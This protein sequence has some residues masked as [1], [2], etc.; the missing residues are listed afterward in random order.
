MPLKFLAGLRAN[1]GHALGEDPGGGGRQIQ[2]DYLAWRKFAKV[3][4]AVSGKHIHAPRA[5][6][7]SEFH[8][9]RMIAHHK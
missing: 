2:H 8:I 3:L 6:P 5:G 7:P 1:V 9:V 4:A